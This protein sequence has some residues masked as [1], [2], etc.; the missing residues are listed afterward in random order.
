MKN[1]IN[2]P[3]YLSIEETINEI[4]KENMTIKNTLKIVFLFM[5]SI[6]LS[7][8][9]MI[10]FVRWDFY[11]TASELRFLMIIIGVTIWSISHKKEINY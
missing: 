11:T 8:I 2:L 4:K 3:F 6:I 5:F 10:M 7:I 9:F 1:K